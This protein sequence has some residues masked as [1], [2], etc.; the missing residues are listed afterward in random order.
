ISILMFNMV[1]PSIKYWND[2]KWGYASNILAIGFKSQC[3][4]SC[5]LCYLDNTKRHRNDRGLIL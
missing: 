5:V 2:K 4:C 1:D 3:S